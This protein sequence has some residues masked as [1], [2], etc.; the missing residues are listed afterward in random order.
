MLYD[1]IKELM[2]K[3][4]LSF[5]KKTIIITSLC[6]NR[7]K[8]KV[9]HKIFKLYDPHK[10]TCFATLCI[11]IIFKHNINFHFYKIINRSMEIYNLL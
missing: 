7:K 1:V 6:S 10:D 11:F 9:H 4:Y 5:N 2:V 8:F 3:N